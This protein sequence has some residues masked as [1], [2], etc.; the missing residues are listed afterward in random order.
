MPSLT[1]KTFSETTCLYV[2]SDQ[3]A[4]KNRDGFIS[5]RAPYRGRTHNE[6][7]TA[8]LNCAVPEGYHV[9]CSGRHIWLQMSQKRLYLIEREWLDI[10]RFFWSPTTHK[11]FPVV[12]RQ[13]LFLLL[14][15]Q[16]F[17]PNCLWFRLSRDLLIE[18]NCIFS[19]LLNY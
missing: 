1:V 16:R 8:Y 6:W 3:L 7:V 17:D 5:I 11:D 10:P 9:E 12:I 14:C 19:K 4:K 18:P 15:A 13:V 2:G